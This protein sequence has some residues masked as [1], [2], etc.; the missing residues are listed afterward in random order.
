M[1]TS[2]GDEVWIVDDVR[3]GS[4]V[5]HCNQAWNWK[6]SGSLEKPEEMS[7]TLTVSGKQLCVGGYGVYV[8]QLVTSAGKQSA[9]LPEPALFQNYPNPFNPSTTIRYGLPQ[10]SAVTLSVYNTLGQKVI[11]LVQETQDAGYHEAKFDGSGLSSGAYFYQLQ[12]G[13]FLRTGRLLLLR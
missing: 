9:L 7:V 2:S 6:F 4:K 11:A 10:R 3:S 12:A 8:T 5:F 1:P 13:G